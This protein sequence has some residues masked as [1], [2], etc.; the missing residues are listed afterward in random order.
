MIADFCFEYQ[1]KKK[2]KKHESLLQLS[3]IAV[4]IS[5]KMYLL[6]TS[7]SFIRIQ[8]LNIGMCTWLFLYSFC[9]VLL[10]LY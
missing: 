5:L 1:K 7:N 6:F 8:T 9:A 2:K 4:F 3:V 10:L